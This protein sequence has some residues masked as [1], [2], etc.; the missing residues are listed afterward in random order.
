MVREVLMTPTS[1]L[2]FLIIV[3]MTSI[4]CVIVLDLP[5]FWGLFTTC[6]IGF[7]PIKYKRHLPKLILHNTKSVFKTMLLMFMISITLPV[8]MSSGT[9]PT[10]IF[11]V[12]GW[13][14]GHNLLISAFWVSL[15][16]SMVLGSAIGT[17]TILLP[18]FSSIAI[19]SGMNYPLLIGA[20]ISG[21]YIGDRC[22]PISSALHL[23]SELTETDYRKNVKSLITSA[24]IPFVLTS[25]LFLT[26]GSESKIT[27]QMVSEITKLN[28][29]FDISLW[30]ILPLALM[31]ALIIIRQPIARV[32]GIVFLICSTM[33]L[34]QGIEFYSLF[35]YLIQGYENMDFT[36]IRTSGF[37]QMI[38]VILVILLSGILNSYLEADSLI[39]PMISP[40][41]THIKSK[42]HLLFNTGLLSMILCMI[43]CS[44]AMTS[45][46]TGKYL[47]PY[48]DKHHIPKEYLVMACSNTGLSIVAMIP[49]N[50][51]GIMISELSGIKTLDYFGYSY[52]ILILLFFS[53]FVYP[54]LLDKHIKY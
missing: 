6:I 41:T 19:Q 5:L 37:K 12:S 11:H 47:S 46:I 14:V 7:F 23:L 28:L 2:F 9:L 15:M 21:I 30:R 20:L 40:F 17:L 1:K 10:L 22:S 16:L 43:T 4:S 39:N 54:V 27:T 52:F 26:I 42:R 3:L 25:I 36:Y 49:W 50:V 48:F 35:E 34:V 38:N 31:L 32:L 53:L 8:L 51:N 29:K 44:Q 33:T 45:I 13:M 24:L 18:L